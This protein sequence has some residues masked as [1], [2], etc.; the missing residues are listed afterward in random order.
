MIASQW[1][2]QL[3][4]ICEYYENWYFQLIFFAQ[5]R[6]ARERNSIDHELARVSR[7]EKHFFTSHCL[8]S[9]SLERYTSKLERSYDD[10]WYKID[11][12]HRI[13]ARDLLRFVCSIHHQNFVSRRLRWINPMMI[14]RQA[15]NCEARRRWVITQLVISHQSYCR[16]GWARVKITLVLAW[17][18][19]LTTTNFYESKSLSWLTN[20]LDS[21]CDTFSFA[22][23]WWA[24][25][26]RTNKKNKLLKAALN[27]V[28]RRKTVAQE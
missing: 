21:Q 5:L 9:P 10:E 24:R 17:D 13:F 18:I 1:Q 7:D 22:V 3:L 28:E 11:L 16:Y 6:R 2:V 20:T 14:G 27:R 8:N 23:V 25:I 12:D 26:V 15:A 19:S 4:K